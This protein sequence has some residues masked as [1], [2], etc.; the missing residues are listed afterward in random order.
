MTAYLKLDHIDKHFDRA[1]QRAEVLK[2]NNLTIDQGRIRFDHRPF[3]LRKIHPAQPDRRADQ[4]FA[5]AVLLENREVNA[6]VRSVRWC[7]RT[8]RCCP[9]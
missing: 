3:R 9:G 4:G 6:R 1:G 2:D 7:S 8:I 5:G